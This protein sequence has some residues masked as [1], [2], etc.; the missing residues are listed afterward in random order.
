MANDAYLVLEDGSVYQGEAFGAESCGYGEV[1]FNTSMTGYQEA[2]TDPS[3][4]GQIVVLTYPL[5]GNYGINARDFE[6]RRIQVAGFVVREHCEYPSHSL[7]TTTLHDFLASQGI[8][9]IAGV[10]TRSITRHLRDRGVMMGYIYSSSEAVPT[11][12][13]GTLAHVTP[14]ELNERTAEAALARLRDMPSYGNVDF[15]KNVTTAEPYTWPPSWDAPS[16]V[17]AP[18]C[19]ILVADF[20][21]KYNILRLLRDRGCEVIAVPATNSAEEI[22]ALKPSGIVLSP[23]PGDPALLEYTVSMVRDLIG[24]VPIIG[25]CLG[26]Q[27]MARALGGNTFKLKFGHRGAN[28]PVKD[29]TT[30]RVYITA[31]NHGYAVD[32]SSL[33]SEIDVTHVNLND[34]TVEGLRHR[35]SPILTVQYHSEAS[36]GPRDNE[37]L[38]DEFLEMVDEIKGK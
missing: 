19:R 2:L 8:P 6:S 5:V 21:L 10:D 1:V 7:S 34:G 30:G 11:P 32:E 20:G 23:G 15:V 29:L 18:R 12:S 38:F 27:I 3:Y 13:H 28:H 24:Q 4:A 33:P 31:Q 36:P 22:M 9:A 16:D 17:P 25:I 26:H 35:E 37:Y 14:A